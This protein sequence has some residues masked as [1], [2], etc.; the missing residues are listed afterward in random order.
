[1]D[2]RNSA[3]M[4]HFVQHR[5]GLSERQLKTVTWPEMA[6]RIVEVGGVDLF[7]GP[8]SVFALEEFHL[9][10]CFISKRAHFKCAR[11]LPS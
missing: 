1:M 4:R 7:W 5:L 6:K 11:W 2:V 3:E 10:V 9:P 8:L